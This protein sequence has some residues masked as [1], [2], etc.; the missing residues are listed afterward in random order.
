MFTPNRTAALQALHDFLPKAGRDYAARRNYDLPDHP[1]V[2]RLSPYLR[3]RLLTEAEVLTAV[4]GRYTLST[5]EKFVQEVYWRTYWKGWLEL[6]PQIWSDYRREVQMGLNRVQSEEGLRAEFDAACAGR[7]EIDC[8]NFWAQELVKTGYLYNH[9]RMWF[10]SIW[11]FTL[12][13]P[14]ALGAD[15]F[16]RHL[17]DGD[18]ASNT[19]SWRWVAGMQTKGKTYLARASNI[20]EYTEGRFRPVAGDLADHADALESRP[21]P[22]VGPMPVGEMWDPDLRTALL[23][24]EE[25]LSPGYL[26]EAGLSPVQTA[27]LK[28]ARDRSP[29]ILAPMVKDFTHRCMADA[30]RRYADKL[31]AVTSATGVQEVADWA[32]ATGAAQIVTPYAPVGP[33]QEALDRLEIALKPDK[34]TLIRVLRD[35]DRAAWPRATHGFFKFRE[36]IPELVGNLKGLRAVS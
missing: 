16:L 26:F 31:G 9:A 10:A 24:S 12:R 7:T 34:I 19:L 22:P 2:S 14:W 18:P 3:H 30:V 1:H 8:F 23:L 13:L 4:L 5:A 36:H 35:Y 11:V 6:R 32:R 33:A 28:S 25:D 15:F 17:L 21:H 27:T 29:L 20:A